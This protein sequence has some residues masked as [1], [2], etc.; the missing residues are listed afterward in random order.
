MHEMALAQSIVEIVR[1]Q[2]RVGS[3]TS[4]RS[5]KLCIGALSYVEPH[6]LEFG[7]EIV[8]RGTIAEGAVLKI[9]RPAGSARCSACNRVFSVSAHGE[10]CPG[11]GQYAWLVVGGDEMRVVELEVE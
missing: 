11:C 3:F 10:P 6:A 5:V 9:D 1:E 8:A 4:V 7:F 2:A